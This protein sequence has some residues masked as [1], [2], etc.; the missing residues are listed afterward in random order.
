MLENVLCAHVLIEHR[1]VFEL[2]LHNRLGDG[3]V[4]CVDEGLI[5]GGRQG[6]LSGNC[7]CVGLRI[8]RSCHDLKITGKVPGTKRERNGNR[9][10][11]WSVGRNL[12]PLH[13]LHRARFYF[14]NYP[15]DCRAL[16]SS[17]NLA[18]PPGIEPGLLPGQ[19]SVIADRPWR[20]I[21]GSGSGTRTHQEK[22]MRLLRPPD[23]IPAILFF[24]L[25]AKNRIANLAGG[26]G[27]E[28][29]LNG[30][31]PFVLSSWTNPQKWLGRQDS[32]L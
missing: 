20:Y 21:F 3:D 30:S 6:V 8:G 16:F 14:I 26:L 10:Y 9:C 2:T 22:L 32:N 29:R 31:K 28:P 19:G 1:R 18:A 7:V 23:L 12:R 15:G 17:T 11:Y 27:F 5:R 25:F 4:R 24:K 13:R